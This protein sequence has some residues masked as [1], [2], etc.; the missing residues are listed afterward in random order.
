MPPSRSVAWCVAGS[1]LVTTVSRR[2]TRCR[3]PR[4]PARI[5]ADA[6]CEIGI[7]IGIG[8]M[9]LIVVASR[10]PRS[11]SE[12]CSISAH[13]YGAAGHLKNGPSTLTIASPRVERRDDVAEPLRALDRVELVA[14]LDEPRRELGDDVG[15]ER[16]DEDV[17]LVRAARR[18]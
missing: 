2:G 8:V 4:A 18:S 6:S 11:T 5:P 15:A 10:T 12:S 14:A 16:D 1:R 3:A 9:T 17:G 13:S 7:G